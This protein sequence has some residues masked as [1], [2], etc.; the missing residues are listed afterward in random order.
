MEDKD[1]DDI[2]KQPFSYEKLVLNLKG[3]NASLPDPD[4]KAF[5][6]VMLEF[7]RIFN[8]MGSA[9]S[10]AFQDITS[11]V[12]IIKRNYKTYPNVSGGL[13]SF[14]KHEAGLKVQRCNGDNN[15]KEAPGPEFKD[16]EST[17]RTILRL[18]WFFDFVSALLNNLDTDRKSS[19][20]TACKAAYSEA[21]GPHHPFPVRAAA[22]V[23]MLAAPNRNKLFHGLFGENTQEE[24]IYNNIKEINQLI[25]PIKTCL[26]TY[27]KENNLT[28]LP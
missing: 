5:T 12:A 25:G 11:K 3:V 8:T 28:E 16:Y 2:K 6:N 24:T 7:V 10:I 20:S 15:K 9:M 26:W 19:V 17:T 22:K 23:A 14:T 18:M 21:L 1:G 13:I 27:Y 4:P